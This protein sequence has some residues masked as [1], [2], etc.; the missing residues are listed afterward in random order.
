MQRPL[1]DPSATRQE[2]HPVGS[3]VPSETTIV[4]APTAS[5]LYH[6]SVLLDSPLDAVRAALEAR[7][8][9]LAAAALSDALEHAAPDAVER[10]RWLYLLG[11][12]ERRRGDSRR[13]IAAFREVTWTPGPLRRE[14]ATHLIEVALGVADCANAKV[15]LAVLG[16]DASL[17]SQWDGYGAGVAR[18]ERRSDEAEQLYR[19]ALSVEVAGT[20]SAV[21]RLEL[22]ELLLERV[23]SCDARKSEVESEIATLLREATELGATGDTLG[24]RVAAATS[25]MACPGESGS[26]DSLG[27]T[28]LNHVDFLLSKRRY[29]EAK[30][31]LSAMHADAA[32]A[33]GR[34]ELACR[35][36]LAN[37]RLAAA[38]DQEED[39]R[40]RFTWIASH[41]ADRD[42]AAR[43]LFLLGGIHANAGRHALALSTYAE[44]IGRFPT[45]R[46]ADDAYLKQARLYRSMG[47][48]KQYV[49]YLDALPERFP[50]GDMTQE[51]LF[52]LALFSMLNRQWGTAQLVLERAE[53]LAD[54]GGF[55]SRR[56][57]GQAAVFS[58]ARLVGAQGDT[59]WASRASET[60]RRPSDELLHADGARTPSFSR[61]A[62]GN[63]GHSSGASHRAQSGTCVISCVGTGTRT[64][65]RAS[66]SGR[67]GASVIGP[68]ITAGYGANRGRLFHD[69]RTICSSWRVANCSRAPQGQDER[70]SRA[71]ARRR[72]ARA[73]EYGLP[74]AICWDS[75]QRGTSCERA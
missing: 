31:L 52:E 47:S 53:R 3:T 25:R 19:S 42:E 40:D 38:I 39:A 50:S 4:V 57:A 11:V 9:E 18:C 71:V 45:H 12:I 23:G 27:L 64:R 16:E 59:D 44:L 15:G 74:E 62:S 65:R 75:E 68:R 6:R 49:E 37:A 14:A 5:E 72:L 67:L 43:A 63:G 28:S 41:C 61:A 17:K 7:D 10:S 1:G 22:A 55:D 46:L 70:V 21:L 56:R 26:Y 66:G 20:R 32:W 34:F 36:E 33:S 30:E 51:G 29:R 8:D 2:P 54:N 69:C 48:E 13:A 60:H 35:V 73:L 58:S 24:A